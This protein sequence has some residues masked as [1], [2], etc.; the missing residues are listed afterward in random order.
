MKKEKSGYSK[1]KRKA[2]YRGTLYVFQVFMIR[3]L[4]VLSLKIR[5]CEVAQ[6]QSTYLACVRPG[7]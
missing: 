6:W 5:A 2:I 1:G 7:V 4:C 3:G